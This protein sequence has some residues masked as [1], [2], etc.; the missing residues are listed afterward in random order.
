MNHENF[1]FNLFLN[2]AQL[3]DLLMKLVWRE[4]KNYYKNRGWSGKQHF[5]ATF[6]NWSLFKRLKTSVIFD[7]SSYSKA[8]PSFPTDKK[9]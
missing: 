4:Q 1:K 2:C 9:R 7:E 5:E 8:V 6:V 3:G